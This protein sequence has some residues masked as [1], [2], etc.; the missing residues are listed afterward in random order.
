MLGY[1]FFNSIGGNLQN[2]ILY[3]HGNVNVFFFYQ[4]TTQQVLNVFAKEKH[5]MFG[6]ELIRMRIGP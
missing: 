5:K 1:S 2:N 3:L 4:P 6:A